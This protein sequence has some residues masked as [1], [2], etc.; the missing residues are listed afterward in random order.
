MVCRSTIVPTC[1]AKRSRLPPRSTV[2][3][4]TGAMIV[5]PRS[6]DV[7]KTPVRCR[8]RACSTVLPS[9]GPPVCTTISMEN[10]RA[11]SCSS[12]IGERRAGSTR[13]ASR[14]M[15][16]IPTIATGTPIALISKKPI[17][18]RP[19]STICPATT[20]LVDVPISVAMPPSSA[21]NDSG[22]S[23]LLT[24]TW[25]RSAHEL[26]CGMSIATIGVL[27][28]NADDSAVGGSTRS[29]GNRYQPRSPRVRCMIGVRAPVFCT[30]AATT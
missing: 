8:S 20:R 1:P 10:R 4:R 14:M 12:A 17:G 18:S 30:A 23:S 21:A 24:D 22:I 25:R 29:R 3:G 6:T 16:P 27:L 19:A 15:A 7:R 9:T 2:S 5:S 26:I 11:A 13:G 28:R